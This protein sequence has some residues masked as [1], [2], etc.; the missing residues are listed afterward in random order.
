MNLN[1]L[2][3]AIPNVKKSDLL[4]S[5]IGLEDMEKLH[6]SL[7]YDNPL[8]YF[9]YLDRCKDLSVEEKNTCY[10]IIKKLNKSIIWIHLFQ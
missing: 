6:P 8:T 10:K 5:K 7:T 1:D 4:E 3:E 2:L 9:V